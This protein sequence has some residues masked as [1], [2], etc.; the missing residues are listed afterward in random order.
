MNELTLKFEDP[1][2]KGVVLNLLNRALAM[3][4]FMNDSKMSEMELDEL[5]IVQSSVYHCM[6][7][8]PTYDIANILNDTLDLK[9][10]VYKEEN[11]IDDDEEDFMSWLIENGH[12]KFNDD[13]TVTLPPPSEEFK[14]R[15]E[16]MRKKYELTQELIHNYVNE[17]FDEEQRHW[18]GIKS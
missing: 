9:E 4:E 13:G 17:H 12:L 5:S 11:D 8:D 7:E 3:Y 15:Q 2:A 18:M 10:P 16:E 6:H 1:I 14:K